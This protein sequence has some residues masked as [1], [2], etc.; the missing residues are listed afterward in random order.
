[1][2]FDV[3]T[4]RN[5][6]NSPIEVGQM[7]IEYAREKFGGIPVIASRKDF[8]DEL[9]F[10]DYNK[11]ITLRKVLKANGGVLI[12]DPEERSFMENFPTVQEIMGDLGLRE[13]NKGNSFQSPFYE[14]LPQPVNDNEERIKTSSHPFQDNIIP[15][16]QRISTSQS[17]Q[18]IQ[19]QEK[20][21]AQ[22]LGIEQRIITPYN[23]SLISEYAKIGQA[24]R[25]HYQMTFA[26][27]NSP[28]S[29]SMQGR[30]F[31]GAYQR[32]STFTRY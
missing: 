22:I 32:G 26:N 24:L 3:N 21:R 14:T 2:A 20:P 27:D 5:E 11:E 8:I 9:G 25:T 4:S 1:M 18:V 16:E 10:R 12:L 23:S 28:L 29:A 30:M 19:T 6:E 17:P 7:T 31:P 15:L 13:E